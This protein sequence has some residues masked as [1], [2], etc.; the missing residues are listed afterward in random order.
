[1]KIIM[2][3]GNLWSSHW[4]TALGLLAQVSGAIVLDSNSLHGIRSSECPR[5]WA[6]GS[7]L[8]ISCQKQII[9]VSPY[10]GPTG[11]W[12][13]NNDEQFVEAKTSRPPSSKKHLT[14][15]RT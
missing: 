3:P 2:G 6:P 1:M 5:R 15:G 11:A 4:Q 8:I 13:F 14:R 7:F 9:N 10:Q 12:F